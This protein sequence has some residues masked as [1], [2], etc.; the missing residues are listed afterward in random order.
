MLDCNGIGLY[1]EI[2]DG[3]DW[4]YSHHSST[5]VA[6]MSL[7]GPFSQSLSDAVTSAVN[8]G[9]VFVVSAGN[10]NDNACNYS[11]ASTPKAI[12]VAATDRNDD[13]ANFSNYGGC[14]DIF[15][16]GVD[17]KS[18]WDTSTSATNTISG[19][20]MASPHVA[21]VA[22]L[23][24]AT[25][26][27][28]APSTVANY[29]SA[30]ST[31]GVVNNETGAPDKLAYALKIPDAPRVSTEQVSCTPFPQSRISWYQWGETGNSA[32]SF[33]AQVQSDYSSYWSTVYSGTRTSATFSPSPGFQRY[34]V[35]VRTTIDGK[36]GPWRYGFLVSNCSIK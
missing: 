2:V 17:I 25:H 4:V 16:P 9:V 3:V 14:V 27:G 19:T 36:T 28:A 8:V 30:W 26:S 5:S 22:A 21:G 11:P 7:G 10:S 18:D 23:Y 13:R 31:H 20:S 29:L 34:T 33:V 32:P 1:S 24:L 15:A 12:T 35:R 6:N